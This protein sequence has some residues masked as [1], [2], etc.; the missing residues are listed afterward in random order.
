MDQQ[1]HVRLPLFHKNRSAPRATVAVGTYSVPFNKQATRWLGIWLDA[2]LS[3]KEH[4]AT[5]MN[6][7]RKALT[8]LRRLTGQMGFI[9]ANCRQVMTACVQLATMFGAELWWKGDHATGTQGGVEEIQ[10]LIN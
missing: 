1:L 5:R 4:H 7:G 9:P 8:R 3:L 6:E 10:W 2:Q